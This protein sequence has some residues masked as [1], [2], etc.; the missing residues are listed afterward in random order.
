MPRR[1]TRYDLVAALARAR[2]ELRRSR[3]EN[4]NLRRENEVCAKQPS[5]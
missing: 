4:R 1:S 2:E 5:R 3:R